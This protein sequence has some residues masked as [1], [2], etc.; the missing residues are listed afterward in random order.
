MWILYAFLA[1]FSAA[2]V[3]IFAKLGLQ[4]VDPTLATT[5][6]AMIMAMFLLIVSLL[7]GKFNGFAISTS[8]SLK[9]WLL[10]SLAGIAGALSWLF[11]FYALK[12]GSATAVVAIDRLS[13][14]FVIVLAALFLQEAVTWRT[15]TGILLM[16]SGALFISLKDN[17]LSL[18]SSYLLRL[19]K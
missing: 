6:R 11:Y 8:V 19:L 9:E 1:A 14:V 7:L 4:N 3:A 16:V 13:I 10:L 5:L 15:I 2:L 17:D 18:I 12:Q